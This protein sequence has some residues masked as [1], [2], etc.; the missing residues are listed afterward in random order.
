MHIQ[1]C[2][3]RNGLRFNYAEFCFK[4][5]VLKSR[6]STYGDLIFP[7]RNLGNKFE[8]KTF[9]YKEDKHAKTTNELYMYGHEKE[10]ACTVERY[11]NK[12]KRKRI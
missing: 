2:G 8:I 1:K 6:L 5:L 11:R 7:S 9:F 4:K 12:L 3:N 10:H